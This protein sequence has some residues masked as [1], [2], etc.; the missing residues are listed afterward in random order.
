MSLILAIL[1]LCGAISITPLCWTIIICSLLRGIVAVYHEE[2]KIHAEREK[3]LEE[4][5]E[6]DSKELVK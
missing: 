3:K 1:G 4:L 5:F 6:S 2:E